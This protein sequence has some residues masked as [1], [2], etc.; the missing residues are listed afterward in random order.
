M[1]K[2]DFWC[3]GHYIMAESI[4]YARMECIATLGYNPEYIRAWREKDELT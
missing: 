2:L 3:D 4:E 1:A